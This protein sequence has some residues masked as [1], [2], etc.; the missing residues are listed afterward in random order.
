M[1]ILNYL[2]NFF[3]EVW[4]IYFTF[5]FL[6]L[7]GKFFSSPSMWLIRLTISVYTYAQIRF[8][9]KFHTSQ[10][11]TGDCGVACLLSVCRFY[12]IKSSKKSLR[13]LAGTTSKGTTLYGLKDAANK[14]GIVSEGYE[15]SINELKQL[16]EPSILHVVM[17]GRQHF[18]V[19]YGFDGYCFKIGDPGLIAGVKKFLPQ[20]L[21]SV[22]KSKKL[23][24]FAVL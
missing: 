24:K 10:F 7:A 15:A 19:C 22:W 16:I 1:I 3:C 18:V 13:K 20:Q 9:D 21:D 8:F 14:L 11:R 4:Q 5:L 23:L 2:P 6:N 12:G 17:N